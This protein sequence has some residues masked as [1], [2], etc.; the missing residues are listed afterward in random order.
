M[1]I[2]SKCIVEFCKSYNF[3]S[4]ITRQIWSKN[5]GN[6]S[7]TDLVLTNFS[8]S[9]QCTSIIETSLLDFLKIIV[10][11]MKTYFQNL[12]PKSM[13]YQ[14]YKAVSNE[15]YREDFVSKLSN[16]TIDAYCSIS[17]YKFTFM[18]LINLFL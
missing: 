17:F 16:E 13:E 5:Q 7:C 1:E 8:Y 10:V 4:I 3:R 11:V 6:S 18:I 12:Q 9:F 15:I 14:N 2:Q